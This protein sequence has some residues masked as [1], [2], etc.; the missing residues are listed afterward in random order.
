MIAPSGTLQAERDVEWAAPY[1][2]Q[3]SWKEMR[4]NQRYDKAAVFGRY[5]DSQ[6]ALL[7]VHGKVRQLQRRLPPGS[8]AR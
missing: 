8:T 4:L 6:L 7:R 1:L 3:A 2:P 5:N